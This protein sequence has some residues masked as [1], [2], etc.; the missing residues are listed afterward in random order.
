MA[1][2]IPPGILLRRHASGPH[3]LL[4]DHGGERIRIVEIW[5]GQAR[6]AIFDRTDLQMVITLEESHLFQLV[7]EIR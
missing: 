7:N 5:K 3:S 1:V 6:R 4:L 2:D